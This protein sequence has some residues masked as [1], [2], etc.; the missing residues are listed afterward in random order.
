[1]A[2]GGDAG[3]M[4]AAARPLVVLIEGAESVDSSLLQDLILVISEVCNSL[5]GQG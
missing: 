3:G 4:E 2:S 5:N 1:M